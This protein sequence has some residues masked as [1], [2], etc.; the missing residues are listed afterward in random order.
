[1]IS[2]FVYINET[3]TESEMKHK[4]KVIQTYTNNSLLN[5]IICFFNKPLHQQYLNNINKGTEVGRKSQA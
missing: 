1:M 5:T 4:Q 2:K 3:H